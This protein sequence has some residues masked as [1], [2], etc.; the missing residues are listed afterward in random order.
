MSLAITDRRYVSAISLRREEVGD[1]GRY[2]FSIPAFRNLKRLQFHP[3]VT[4]FVGE[5]GMGK[6]TLIEAI[7]VKMGFN[8]EGGSR[9]FR[10]DTR[11]SHSELHKY[12][13][14]EKGAARPNDGYFLRAESFYNVAT[15][16]G[17]LDEEP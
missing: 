4:F 10:F 16:I 15:E 14:I 8:P 1:F 13:V 9:N 17:R 2:P 6:S 11:A 3:A 12:L 5:N 7:A